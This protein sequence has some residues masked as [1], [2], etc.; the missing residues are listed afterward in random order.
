MDAVLS[1]LVRVLAEPGLQ[2]QIRKAPGSESLAIT[3]AYHEEG[4]RSVIR[5][6]RIALTTLKESI[7]PD[8]MLAH[9]IDEGARMLAGERLHDTAKKRRK[10][11]RAAIIKAQS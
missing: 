9:V 10:R 3:F 5:G 1:T 7:A 2:V 4:K 11:K 6:Q 8:Q